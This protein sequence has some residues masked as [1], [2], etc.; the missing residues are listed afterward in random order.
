[1]KPPAITLEQ[2]RELLPV[3]RMTIPP[4]YQDYNQHMNIRWYLVIFDDAGAPLYEAIDLHPDTL[5]KQGQ[6]T[7]DLEHHIH[8]LKEVHIGDEISVYVRMVGRSAKRMHY[9]MFMVNETR[10]TLASIFECV[11]T[12]VN[13]AE[14]RTMPYPDMIMAGIDRLLE[15][16]QTLS[17][18]AP[19]CGV[20]Q[21]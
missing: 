12:F 15:A 21:A 16:H 1:M 7:F 14:R 3:Y 4:T 20:M 18:D 10:G 2:V 5:L 9:L 6:S 13:L 19:V 8:Y 17:W 11:N